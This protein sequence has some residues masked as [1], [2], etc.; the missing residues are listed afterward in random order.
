MLWGRAPVDEWITKLATP[1]DWATLQRGAPGHLWCAKSLAPLRDA[2][3][4]AAERGRAPACRREDMSVDDA[5]MAANMIANVGDDGIRDYLAGPTMQWYDILMIFANQC[6]PA[7]P[8]ERMENQKI[9]DA[10]DEAAMRVLATSSMPA[11][12]LERDRVPTI[13]ADGKY[14][15]VWPPPAPPAR[16]SE[17]GKMSWERDPG[18]PLPAEPHLEPELFDAEKGLED[19]SPEQLLAAMLREDDPAWSAVKHDAP[20]RPDTAH[21]DEEQEGGDDESGAG[22]EAGAL[23]DALEGEDPWGVWGQPVEPQRDKEEGA[24]EAAKMVERSTQMSVFLGLI[25]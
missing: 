17:A 19:A 13:E 23:R 14:T 9:I 24:A 22:E 10:V 5:A 25:L 15:Y 7:R 6:V 16:A 18:A 8:G 11:R 2:A 20:W 21:L 4:K 1:E 3:E 12:H